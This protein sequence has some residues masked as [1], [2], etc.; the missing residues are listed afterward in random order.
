LMHKIPSFTNITLASSTKP[1]LA[2]FA[3]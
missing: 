2:C 1:K 3:G